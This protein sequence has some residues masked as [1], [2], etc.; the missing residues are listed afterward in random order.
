MN[1]HDLANDA[2]LR[3]TAKDS[4]TVGYWL[5][6]HREHENL[7]AEELAARLGVDAR[8][9]ARLALC[10][11]PDPARFAAD[12]AVVAS[13]CGANAGVLANLIRQERSLLAFATGT[14]TA[15]PEPTLLIAAH[16]ADQ[17]PPGDDRDPRRT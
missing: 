8:G 4:A 11:A 2:A 1:P 14:P 6:R 5:A 17:P 16:D 15:N 12:L 7:T 13:H 3:A 9:L 10:A